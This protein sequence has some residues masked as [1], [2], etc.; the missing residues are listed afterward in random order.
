M[1]FKFDPYNATELKIGSWLV[2]HEHYNYDI[3]LYI[4]M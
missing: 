2:G 4:T 3:E 1:W